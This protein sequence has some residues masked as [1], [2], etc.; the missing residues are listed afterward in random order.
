MESKAEISTL[1]RN[2]LI[3]LAL[4]SIVNIAF[5]WLAFDSAAK[6]LLTDPYYTESHRVPMFSAYVLK[7]RLMLGSLVL[8]LIGMALLRRSQATLLIVCAFLLSLL[9]VQMIYTSILIIPYSYSP[10]GRL[11]P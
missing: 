5:N 11:L 8:A 1:R 9:F 10:T 6:S 7:Y 4:A 3:A 2:L